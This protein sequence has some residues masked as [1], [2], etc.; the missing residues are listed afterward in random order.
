M[1]HTPCGGL[2]HPLR[3]AST[4]HVFSISM[5]CDCSVAQLMNYYTW[6]LMNLHSKEF[7]LTPVYIRSCLYCVISIKTLQHDTGKGGLLWIL[8]YLPDWT[9]EADWRC[10]SLE[11]QC[12]YKSSKLHEFQSLHWV[13]FSSSM[14]QHPFPTGDF[15]QKER[16]RA[17]INMCWTVFHSWQFFAVYGTVSLNYASLGI[18]LGLSVEGRGEQ[19][20]MWV[21]NKARYFLLTEKRVSDSLWLAEGVCCM[22]RLGSSQ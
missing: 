10:N 7:R 6:T 16:M 14:S 5:L 19:M 20:E 11:I 3:T 17:C 13:C 22:H 8:A 4:C 1:L 12:N 18:V 15:T 2:I 21:R 9:I